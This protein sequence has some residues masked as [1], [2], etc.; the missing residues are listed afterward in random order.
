MA[1]L[2]AAFPEAQGV[3]AFGSR[4]RGEAGPDSDL[5]LAVLV[6][7]RADPLA[8]WEAAHRLADVA[9]CHVDLVDLRAASTVLQFQ[10]VTTG[11]RWLGAGLDIEL[12]ELLVLREKQELDAARA[13]HLAD[14]RTRGTVY[15]G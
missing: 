12:F 2:L 8:I 5:D 1:C 15:R 9:G 3:Y 4:V 7:P 6:G 11:E 10:V 13:A 14:I